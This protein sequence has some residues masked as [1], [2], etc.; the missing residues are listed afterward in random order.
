MAYS[1]S[2][3]MTISGKIWV[4]MMDMMVGYHGGSVMKGY[5]RGFRHCFS[6][7]DAVRRRFG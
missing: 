1:S 6:T 7:I 5:A 4:W 2:T 3:L